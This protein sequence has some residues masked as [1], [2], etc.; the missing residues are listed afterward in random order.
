MCAT[1]DGGQGEGTKGLGRLT[2]S[3]PSAR[4]SVPRTCSATVFRLRSVHF[5]R[6]RFTAPE[7]PCGDECEQTVIPRPLARLPIAC[8]LPLLRSDHS[9]VMVYK[10]ARTAFRFLTLVAHAPTK[11]V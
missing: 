4:A 1:A 6:G 9:S 3:F 11:P 2:M 8:R 7:A 5:E 10:L